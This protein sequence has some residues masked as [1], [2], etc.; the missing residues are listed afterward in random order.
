MLTMLHAIEYYS[1]DGV[2]GA[3]S[4]RKRERSMSFINTW[5]LNLEKCFCF[6]KKKLIKKEKKISSKGNG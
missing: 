2:D 6:A 4:K 3:D 1:L 5:S